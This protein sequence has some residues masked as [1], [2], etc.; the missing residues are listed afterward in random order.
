MVLG[1]NR[2]KVIGNFICMDCVRVG[3]GWFCYVCFC[4]L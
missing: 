3:V 2:G 4:V 1:W